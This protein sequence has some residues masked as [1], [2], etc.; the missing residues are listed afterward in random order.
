MT[1]VTAG[2]PRRPVPPAVLLAP[3]QRPR[4]FD[5]RLL[6]AADLSREQEYHIGMRRLHNLA[7]L[8]AGV[9]AGLAVTDEPGGGGV[10]V[11]PGFAI[12][13]WGR[14]VIVPV[15][16]RLARPA[17]RPKPARRCFVVLR[18]AEEPID[19][20]PTLGHAGSPVEPSAVRET[21]TMSIESKPPAP[22]DPALILRMLAPPTKRRLRRTGR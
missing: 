6:T 16:E 8:G 3:P 5:G 9:V 13:P 22:D 12:D 10:L 7:T 20:M 2:K 21:Y 17:P 1:R 11:S 18:Y 15:A 4:F 14:E 19:P